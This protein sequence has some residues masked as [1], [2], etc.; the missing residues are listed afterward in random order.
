MK[1]N[2][3][4]EVR[5]KLTDYGRSLYKHHHN[6]IN[7]LVVDPIPYTAPEEDA[8][9]WSKWQLWRLIKIFGPHMS[10][11]SERPF[12]TEIEIIEK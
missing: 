4:H 12:E 3:N 9:G 7:S 6:Y 1:F 2:I 8:E 10:M 11:S 5:V